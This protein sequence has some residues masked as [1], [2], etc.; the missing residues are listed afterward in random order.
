M[1]LDL[2]WRDGYGYLYLDGADLA[3]DDGLR[4]AVLVSLFTDRRARDDDRLP[5]GSEDRRGHW[6]DSYL[7]NGDLEG[8]RLWL[9]ERE[10]VLPDVLRRA[11][12]YSR[13]G[14]H[15]MLEDGVAATVQ[16]TAWTTGRSDLNLRIVITRPTGEQV[17]LEFL[18]IWQQES[19]RAV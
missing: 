19:Q 5:D 16:A 15:W 11:E 14:L 6:S 1:D 4:T 10:K 9:L 12:D 8:S 17:E 3:V 7:P 18:N 13:E 2:Q